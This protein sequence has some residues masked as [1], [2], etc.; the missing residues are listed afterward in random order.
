VEGSHFWVC[1]KVYYGISGGRGLWRGFEFFGRAKN[2]FWGDHGR[3]FW[4]L[5]NFLFGAEIG[6]GEVSWDFIR[7]N[8]KIIKG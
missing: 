7:S 2:D 1:K 6:F 5:A 4:G 8:R 3:T